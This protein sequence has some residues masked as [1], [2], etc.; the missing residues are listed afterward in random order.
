MLKEAQTAQ[1]E[2][3]EIQL[4]VVGEYGRHFYDQHHIPIERTFLYTAQNPTMDR[5]REIS[6]LLLD[7]YDRGELKKI[8]VVYTDM[9]NSLDDGPVHPAAALPPGPVHL[10]HRRKRR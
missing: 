9:K 6:A 1:E 2:H 3:A 8:Y 10:A 7:K 4:F 5:A